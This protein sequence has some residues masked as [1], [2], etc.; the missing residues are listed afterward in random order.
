MSPT[1]EQLCRAGGNRMLQP[2]SAMVLA[3]GFGKRMRP[4]STTVPKPLVKVCGV[5][6]IDHCLDGIARAGI[7]MAVV[8]VHYLADQLEAHLAGRRAPR[9]VISDERGAL[10][11]TGG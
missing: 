7:E 6:L 3:A 1:S 2:K 11:D 9:I 10:L 5:P 8:N 4:L